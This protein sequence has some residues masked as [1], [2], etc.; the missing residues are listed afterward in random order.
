MLLSAAVK[1]RHHSPSQHQMEGGQ[2]H[3]GLV[4]AGSN[5]LHDESALLPHNVNRTY[6]SKID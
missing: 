4:S 5:S 3:L 2:S 1:A 6:R